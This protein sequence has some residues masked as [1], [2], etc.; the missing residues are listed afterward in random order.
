VYPLSHINVRNRM[1][2]VCRE[3]DVWTEGVARPVGSN[4]EVSTVI[5]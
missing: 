2:F 5:G 4:G 3:S 1:Y